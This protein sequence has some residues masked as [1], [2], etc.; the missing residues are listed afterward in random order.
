MP[1]RI[2]VRLVPALLI[3]LPASE[4]RGDEEKIPVKELPGAVRKAAKAMF[5]TALI[6]GASKEEDDKTT[7]EVMFK[8]E[9]RA[10][11][12]TMAADGKI[13]E[14]EKEIDDDDLPRAVKK[15]VATKYP[16]RQDRQG[17]AGDQGRGRPGPV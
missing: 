2:L 10:I 4:S 11:D 1:A 16:C 15:A 12:V 6:V 17:R 3:G 5:P 7:Y 14:I 8:H 9:G 13:L